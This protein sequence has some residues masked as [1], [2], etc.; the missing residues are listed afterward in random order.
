[1]IGEI[2]RQ[3]IGLFVDDGFLA[4]TIL[5][6]VAVASALVFLGAAPPWFAGLMLTLALPVALAASVA[7]SVWRA[8]PPERDG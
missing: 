4:A 8:R 6:A 7:L 2:A 3:L 5:A 1:M